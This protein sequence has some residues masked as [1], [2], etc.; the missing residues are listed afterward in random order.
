[1]TDLLDGL[2]PQQREAVSTGD[3][4]VLVLAGPGSGKTRVLTQ[5]VAWLI[6]EH[7]VTPYRIMAV[8]F[9]NK[10]AR[11]MRS[12]IESM[13]DGH[14]RGISIGTFHAICARI[15]RREA[16]HIPLGRD[17]VIYDS[18]DQQAL[19]KQALADLN[20]DEKRYQPNR[21]HSIISQAKN[22]LIE[23]QD[24]RSDSY[25]VEAAGRVY[26]RYQE[27]LVTNNAA[28]FDDLLMRTAL[29]L[30]E[31]EEVRHAYQHAYEHVLVDEFQ[32]TNGAQYMLLRQL[33][34][35]HKNIFCVGDPDQS[36]YAWRG[37]DYRNVERFNEDFPE[38]RTI[39]LEQ[40]YRSTQVI[41]D[42]AMAVIGK[43][44]QRTHKDLFTERKG[45]PDIVRYEAYDEM[46][47]AQF[48]VDTIATLTATAEADPGGCA[49]M[50]RTNAQSRALEDA[51]I[52]AGLPYRL[53]GATRFYARREI[54]DLLAYLRV[55][56]NPHDT[57][58]LLRIINA[59]TRGIGAK[60]VGGIVAWGQ[61]RGSSIWEALEASMDGAESPLNGRATNALGKF[62]A[63]V[64]G[65]RAVAG[66]MNVYDLLGLITDEIG[67]HDSLDDGTTQGQERWENVGEL[68]NVAAIYDGLPLSDFLQEVALVSDVDNL[69]EDVRAPSLLTLHAAK[70]LEFPVV[71]ITGLEEGL[72]PHQRSLDDPDGIAEERRLVYVGITRSE[73]R[74]YL[75]HAFRRT[76]WGEN[77]IAM[78]SR[79]L[80]DIPDELVTGNV[81]ARSRGG[82]PSYSTSQRATIWGSD[83]QSQTPLET[84]YRSGQRVKHAKFGEGI[85]IESRI[86]S[87]EEE[88]SVAFEQGG[89]KRLLA[90]MAPLQILD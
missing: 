8:T 43:N 64:K 82:L 46:D 52:R 70:G 7:D 49:V 44:T 89:L 81:A 30:S 5:R 60:T 3:G 90:S 32:D 67:F 27:L 39:L 34:A 2:N 15:L 76:M 14:L 72:L 1:M 38:A 25:F 79:F 29:L 87:G 42:A 68:R 83:I 37:A 53:V 11:E 23:P 18:A 26:E 19:I 41:L 78:P 62:T 84:S 50:Y 10:A 21:V 85:V 13:L 74:L 57:V 73:E 17:Y 24:F 40:N 33:A 36:I 20:L 56:H 28:D 88:V 47:E 54:K 86:T 35:E 80:E 55:V 12:R 16:D 45:G 9:T 4:P 58:S 66:E 48:V 51:F 71:F 59:P 69:P 61:E 65:W 77:T 63:L 75:L 6:K 22:D 31:N